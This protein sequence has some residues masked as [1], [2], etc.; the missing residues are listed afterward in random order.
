MSGQE[1]KQILTDSQVNLSRLADYLGI[2]PQTLSSRFLVKSI[3]IDFLR[4]I[5][6]YVGKDL[7]GIGFAGNNSSNYSN[8]IPIYNVRICA[9]NGVGIGD[10]EPAE[11]INIPR[12]K[13]CIGGYVYGES[14][15]GM[16]NSGDLLI[17]REIT[18]K[19]LLNYG[20]PY[21]LN[22]T[23]IGAVVKLIYSSRK[24]DDYIRLVAYNQD[25]YENGD[26]M[27]PDMEIKRRDVLKWFRIV[28]R[29]E[30]IA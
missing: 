29:H 2:K 14:M 6:E 26:R 10:D 5:N 13:D 8:G 4:Q 18:D 16:F 25:K 11:Y 21:V 3:K 23:E 19:S 12:L 7:F 1:L 22:I 27:F 30:T 20:R 28:E 24:G 9:G 17:M 15:R